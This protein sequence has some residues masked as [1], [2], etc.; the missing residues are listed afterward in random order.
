M[1]MPTNFTVVPV[2]D[3]SRKTKDGNE[4]ADVDDNNELKEEDATG[5]VRYSLIYLLC[6]SESKSQTFSVL[7]H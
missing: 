6:A 3:S 2:K 5:E 1:K 7:K 4:D